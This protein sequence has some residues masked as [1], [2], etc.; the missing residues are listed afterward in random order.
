MGG[1]MID[2]STVD[3]SRVK[4]YEGKTTFYIMIVS[5]VAGSGGL[6]F[7]YDNGVTGGVIASKDFDALF[8]PSLL[9]APDD[10]SPYCT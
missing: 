6:L 3:E 8:F 7:G 2:T 9:N 1:A 4:L 10:E 5:I